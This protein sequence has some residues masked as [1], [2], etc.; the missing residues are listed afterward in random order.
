[1]TPLQLQL[2]V[3]VR[4]AYDLQKVRICISNRLAANFRA[5]MGADAPDPAEVE[6]G[7]EDRQEDLVVI[8]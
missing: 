1:M 6:E 3:F 7:E 8:D 4:G 5:K 2:R